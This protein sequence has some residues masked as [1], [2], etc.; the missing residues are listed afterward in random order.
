[1]IQHGKTDLVRQFLLHTRAK[2]YFIQVG[3]E[4]NQPEIVEMLMGYCLPGADS[5]K[6]ACVLGFYD[7]VCVLLRHLNPSCPTGLSFVMACSHGHLEIIRLLVRER[8]ADVTENDC[9]GLR[10]AAMM[11]HASV[12]QYLLKQ[13][14]V[15][16]RVHRNDAII[17][18]C[19]NGHLEVVEALLS[20]WRVDPSA[21]M[22]QA[23]RVSAANGFTAV[24]DRLLKD[25]RVDPSIMSQTII[26]GAI[27]NGHTETVVR[28][29]EDRRVDFK[30]VSDQVLSIACEFGHL[31]ILR[32]LLQHPTLQ[33]DPDMI[34]PLLTLCMHESEMD[35]EM[36]QLLLDDGRMNPCADNHAAIKLAHDSGNKTAVRVLL[37][38]VRVRES[39]GR[40]LN[41][42]SIE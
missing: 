25:E 40:L 42:S 30:S 41:S 19:V 1:M 24:V 2:K 27:R 20:D 11:G 21:E 34:G 9:M 8:R 29:L 3:I 26:M 31:Q 23:L 39:V 18:A 22:Q 37:G 28:L 4:A 14:G 16:P 35:A 5:L 7:V 15:D 12:V 32:H 33:I 17:S 10:A 38:D 6:T 36:M 13:P